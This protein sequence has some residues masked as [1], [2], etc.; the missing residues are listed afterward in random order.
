MSG[1][2][3]LATRPSVLPA[4]PLEGA[5]RGLELVNAS[6][7]SDAEASHIGGQTADEGVSNLPIAVYGTDSASQRRRLPERGAATMYGLFYDLEQIFSDL[8]YG[9]RKTFAEIIRDLAN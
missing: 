7:I 4:Q 9:L 6:A 5:I 8:K 1:R 3:I 2:L